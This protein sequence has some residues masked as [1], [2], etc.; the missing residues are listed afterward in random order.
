VTKLAGE[1]ADFKGGEFTVITAQA[2]LSVSNPQAYRQNLFNLLG[3][4]DPLDVLGQTAST[5][6]EIL[7]E[8]PATVL[9]TRPLEGKWTPNEVIGHLTDSE[10]V[11]GYRL[12]LIL[13]EDNPPIL[14]TNQDLWVACQRHN[15]REPSEF[16]EMFRTMRQFNLGM[17]KRMS[18]GDLRRTGLHN[19]RGPESLGVMLRMMAGDDLS[20]LDQIG[21]YIQAFS[22][23]E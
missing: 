10:W 9:R 7:R 20:H 16:V 15:E 11:Y 5:L 4:R 13:C 3:D 21:R 2:G 8:N 14:G 6:D 1:E 22:L 23:R 18:P 12:R 17:W 19:E